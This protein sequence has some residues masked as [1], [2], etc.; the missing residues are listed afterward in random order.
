M[1]VGLT[2]RPAPAAG[3]VGVCVGVAVT[4]LTV[5]VAVA[6]GDAG[7]VG[8]PLGPPGLV[9]AGG[10]E[11]AGANGVEVAGGTG[12]EVGGG[13]GVDV[14]GGTGVEVAG[15]TGV[16][17]AGGE[18]GGTGVLVGGPGVLV[19]GGV[20]V[21]GNV[22]ATQDGVSGICATRTL[23]NTS[24]VEPAPVSTTDAVKIRAMVLAGIASG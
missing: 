1:A 24:P 5:P 21:G 19:G 12:V 22:G 20:E 17:V 10:V 15:A 2:R 4:P 23:L 8:A 16:E 14:A 9:V 18:V 3:A 6:C 13:T 11:V 7:V